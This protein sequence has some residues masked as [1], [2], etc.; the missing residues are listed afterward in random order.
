MRTCGWKFS[1]PRLMALRQCVVQTFM[2]AWIVTRM[3]R[4][5][6]HSW[7][8]LSAPVYP[9]CTVRATTLI[10]RWEMPL[11]SVSGFRNGWCILKIFLIGFPN[12]RDA[13][14]HWGVSTQQ[15]SCWDVR[16]RGAWLFFLSTIAPRDSSDCT[17]HYSPFWQHG[18]SWSNIQLI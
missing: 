4:P 10:C 13:K 1:F 7:R 15:W 9:T 3:G 12:P 5:C 6:M 11:K 8:K 18:I 16:W 17:G 14:P 2:L